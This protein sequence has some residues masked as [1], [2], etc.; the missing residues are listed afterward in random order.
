MYVTTGR[1][2]S[3]N[4]NETDVLVFHGA[5]DAPTVDVVERG[6]GAGLIVNDLSYGQF[7]GYL[8]LPTADFTL[9][10]RT[11]NSLTTVASYSAP[12]ATLNAGG[13][14]LVVVASGFLNTGNNNSGPAF[15]LFA[16]LPS[17]GALLELP[18]VAAN[19]GSAQVQVIH[20]SAD[21]AAAEV[22]IYINGSLEADDFAFRTATGFL[23][24]P[25]EVD[26]EVAIAPAGSNSVADSLRRFNYKLADGEKYIVIANGIVSPTGYSP[27]T[28]FNLY[29]YTPARDE[30]NDA[31]ET[32]VLVFHG[33]T[34]APTVD[35]V[36]T[37]VG[38]GT[39]VDDLSYGEF[40]G[41]LELSTADYEIQVRDETGATTVACYQ[42]PLAS[43]SQSGNAL[44]VLASGFLN[45]TNN[46]NGAAF[47]LFAASA[48][49]GA[50]LEL[51]A[52]V[53]VNVEDL[54]TSNSI[55]IYP[56]P[57]NSNTVSVTA[58]ENINKIVLFDLAGAEIANENHNSTKAFVNLPANISSGVYMMKVKTTS[59]TFTKRIVVE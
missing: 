13:A 50:L 35:V 59:N 27:A 15:G 18:S 29:V 5:T 12:L 10:V 40:E 58:K 51:P 45:R 49:G 23:P 19:T 31:N 54:M 47:G 28:P 46:S 4:A 43:L 41:Y 7:E 53:T 14:A 26:I 30:S 36:E 9:D 56:N 34:D 48:S 3:G 2:A 57:V 8:D 38:A 55:N 44:V 20:N 17:G 22:D 16:A 39:I 42:A 24:L 52:C 21:A 11:S 33:A 6:V 1:N 25:S 37:L 32:D